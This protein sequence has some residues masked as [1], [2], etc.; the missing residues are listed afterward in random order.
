ML[1]P[2]G[3]KEAF[4]CFSFHASIHALASCF[5]SP[6]PG[7]EAADADEAAAAF[8]AAFFSSCSSVVHSYHRVFSPFEFSFGAHSPG[9]SLLGGLL[10]VLTPNA[11]HLPFNTPLASSL[12]A[13]EVQAEQI[14]VIAAM[15]RW[16]RPF[17]PSSV[18][19]C[20]LETGAS[21]L[22]AIMPSPV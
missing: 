15:K 4:D 11:S 1:R 19:Y 5:A 2:L 22:G 21:P 3:T 6:A 13:C 17:I 16:L 14:S 12:V 10:T 18:T 8:A 20:V 9:P 7:A